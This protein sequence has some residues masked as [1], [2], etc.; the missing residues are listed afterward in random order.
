MIS[1]YIYKNANIEKVESA[2]V[3]LA[4]ATSEAS[5]IISLQKQW[6]DPK[7]SK[8]ILKLKESISTQKIKSFVIKRKK[9]TASFRNLTSKEMNTIVIRL[10]NIAVQIIKLH[11][12]IEGK[13][14]KMEI[15]C[16]W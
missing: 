3:E 2:E 4:K 5:E 14:Y 6:N 15:K 11:I 10:E 7:L 8:R 12:K 13:E 9:L 1:S 16:K